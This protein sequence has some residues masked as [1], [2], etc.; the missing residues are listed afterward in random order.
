MNC[1][2]CRKRH[3]AFLELDLVEVDYCEG[4]Q[5]IWLDAGELELLF[6]D[7]ETCHRFLTIGSATATPPGEAK[8]ICPIC[9]CAMTKECTEGAHP[10]VFDHCGRGDG[11]WFDRGELETVLRHPDVID[12]TVADFLRDVFARGTSR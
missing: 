11:L 4:C 2:V 10:I 9:D 8:R 7:A 1:P 12:R 3:L 6:G 5:G